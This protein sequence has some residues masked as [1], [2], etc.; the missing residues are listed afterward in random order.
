MLYRNCIGDA[1]AKAVAEAI[2]VNSTLQEINLNMNS[3]GDEGA[4]AVAEAMKFNSTLHEIIFYWNY[5]GDDLQSQIAETL[6]DNHFRKKMNYR[7]FICA[8]TA[9]QVDFVRLRFDK[10]ILRFLYYPILEV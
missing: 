5:I 4:K 3:I 8:F 1:G 2:K 6:K 7:K 10:M 9:Y